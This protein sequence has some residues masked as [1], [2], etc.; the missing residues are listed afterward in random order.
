ME[1]W[2]KLVRVGLHDCGGLSAVRL[3]NRRGFRILTYH[4]FSPDELPVLDE[5]C[6]HI[7]RYYQPVTMAAVAASLAGDPLPDNALVVTVD[8]GYANFA[9]AQKTFKKHGIPVVMYLVTDFLDRKMWF[10]WN[11]ILYAFLHT[12][13]PEFEIVLP[14]RSGLPSRFPLASDAQR[15]FAADTVTEAAKLLP[16]SRRRTVCDEVEERLHVQLPELPA[17]WQPLTWDQVREL[18]REGVEFGAHTKTHAILPAVQ[19]TEELQQEIVWS[20][21]RIE[22]EL[23]EA[24]I[25]FAYPNGQYDHRI[26]DMVRES[27]FQTAATTEA[28][29]NFRPDS[30]LLR[31]FSADPQEP[32]FY[33]AEVISGLRHLRFRQEPRLG[34]PPGEWSRHRLQH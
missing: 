19:D 8:D 9:G 25:H 23:D 34:S 1:A 20:K 14:S 33:F 26:V 15:R 27:G 31:R 3:W 24:V 17:E 6:K 5:Q 32:L 28:G 16:D 10:W 29:L 30:M 2:K 22:E 13:Y 4:A 21:K 12:D 18:R 11:R 7:R